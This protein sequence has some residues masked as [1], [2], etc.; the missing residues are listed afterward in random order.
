ML[1]A[2]APQVLGFVVFLI[3][4]SCL[5]AWWMLTMWPNLRHP[6]WGVTP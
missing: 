2:I 5:M 4:L 1:K 6:A 3:V